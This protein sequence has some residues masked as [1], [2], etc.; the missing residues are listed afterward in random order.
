MRHMP[1]EPFLLG[2]GVGHSFFD[3][4]VGSVA[5]IGH[6]IVS[7]GTPRT[8]ERLIFRSG[9]VPSPPPPQHGAW[10]SYHS[11]AFLQGNGAYFFWAQ[12]G[13]FSINGTYFTHIN[14]PP[15]IGSGQK[16]SMRRG[17][18]KN[19]TSFLPAFSHGRYGCGTSSV[20][21]DITKSFP[22][23]LTGFFPGKDLAQFSPT[24]S[25]AD[26][27]WRS[28]TKTSLCEV[29]SS[30]HQICSCTN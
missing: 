21:Q 30:K 11:L 15:K 25:M 14:P 10:N 2:V 12:E 6:W 4:Q 29:N 16:G 20:R 3:V 19:W 23:I 9:S 1:C 24:P 8:P 17:P 27:L 7:V 22:H 26:P 18:V 28:P 5:D 13:S